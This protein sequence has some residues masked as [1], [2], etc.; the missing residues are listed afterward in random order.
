M[1][2]FDSLND[3]ARIDNSRNDDKPGR[4]LQRIDGFSLPKTQDG[5]EYIRIA[6]TTVEVLEDTEGQAQEVGTE[7]T[8]ALFKGKFDYTAKE[9]RHIFATGLGLTPTEASDVPFSEI[10][11]RLVD[12]GEMNG[13]VVEILVETAGVRTKG[14]NAGEPFVNHKWIRNYSLQ[15]AQQ[16]AA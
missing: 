3:K 12:K 11:E 16:A 14:R 6:K 2:I 8:Q 1:G 10:K 15:E 7:T 9:V 4:Y 13:Q 5:E